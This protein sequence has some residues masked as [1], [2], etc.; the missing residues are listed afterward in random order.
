[1]NVSLFIIHYTYCTYTDYTMHSIL[2]IPRY[3]YYTVPTIAYKICYACCAVH[4]ILHIL[5][6]TYYTTHAILYTLYYAYCTT[7]TKVYTLCTLSLHVLYRTFVHYTYYTIHAHTCCNILTI[8]QYCTYYS[9]HNQLYI[10]NY[11]CYTNINALY[12]LC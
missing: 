2:H 11:A 10:L 3:R 5:H 9:T 1:M 4:A 12:I 6:N 8:V 7:H